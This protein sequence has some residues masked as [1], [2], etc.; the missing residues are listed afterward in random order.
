MDGTLWDAVDSYCQIWD[1]TIEQCGIDRRPVTRDELI[2][3]MGK[4]IDIIIGELL[5]E[6]AGDTR[7]LEMLDNNERLMMPKLGG[8]LYPGVKSLM[9]LLAERY[10]LFMVSN[11]SAHGL[12]NFLDYTGLKPYVTDTLS[13]GDNNC[14]K[15]EN[16]RL[17]MDAH[18]LKTA[19]YVGDTAGDELSSRQAGAAFA[20]AAY[21]FGSAVSPDFT[22]TKFNDL[23]AILL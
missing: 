1:A 9:P 5:P 18:G 11:C 20:W 15:A 23:Q 14:G 8:R 4:T 19:L 10:K 12:P 3:L 16:I 2:G 22:L 13:H 7:F 6:N 21:G 17:I